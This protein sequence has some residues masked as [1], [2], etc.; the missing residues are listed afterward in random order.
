MGRY[1]SVFLAFI[2][3]C[4][5]VYAQSGQKRNHRFTLFT[6][7]VPEKEYP[8][9]LQDTPSALFTMRQSN[10][11]FLSIYRLGIHE[12]NKAFSPKIS[13]ITQVVLQGLF[14]MPL[15][16]EEGHRSVLTNEG[17]GSISRPFFNK[18]LAAYVTG[19]SDQSLIDLRNAN[20]PAFTRMYIG[21]LES[22]YALML[23]ENSLMNFG[24]ESPRTL[25]IEY[26]MR[27]VS[28]VSYYAMGLFK[29]NMGLKEESNELNR[30]IAGM[31]VYG[32][33]RAL[34]NPTE[35]FKRYVD[36]ADL[37]PEEKRFVKRVGWRSFINLIDP[38]VLSI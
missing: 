20:L 25:W 9:I 5:H 34:H 8:F 31:D 12:L 29:Y 14:F 22:D 33:I 37:Q 26:A 16:H 36:Y 6:D 4:G 23:R 38:T 21:G 28:L 7:T 10:E 2:L 17:I 3:F 32:A 24:D 35:E 15:T 13:V 18:N 30:D 27:K 19:V 1:L 11:N